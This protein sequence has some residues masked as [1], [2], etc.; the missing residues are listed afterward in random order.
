[1]YDHFLLLLG[2]WDMAA[3]N[4]VWIFILKEIDENYLQRLASIGVKRV[5]LKVADGS[6][7]WSSQCTKPIVAAFKAAGIEVYGWGYHYAASDPA[8]DIAAV[9]KAMACGLAG[10]VVDIEAEA[11]GEGSDVPAAALLA[12]LRPLVPAGCLGYTSFGAVQLHPGV[13]WKTLNDGTDFAMPQIY[14]EEF[15]LG[16]SIDSTVA[17]CMTANQA[18]PHIK[19]IL[20]IW[21]S[22]KGAQFPSTVGDLQPHLD[23]FPGSSIWRIP[24]LDEPGVAWDLA[25]H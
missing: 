18:L 22:E 24:G 13:P 21:S 10:Y 5:Y 14:Y 4:G 9:S 12:G 1:M 19:Q 20:P 7:F 3:P 2:E 25:Y 15:R 6:S 11:E 17:K 16:G 23:K 8:P